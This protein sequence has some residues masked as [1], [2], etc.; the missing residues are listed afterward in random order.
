MHVIFIKKETGIEQSG[1]T[2]MILKLSGIVKFRVACKMICVI[3]K[4]TSK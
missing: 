1:Y 2:K 3:C 4:I